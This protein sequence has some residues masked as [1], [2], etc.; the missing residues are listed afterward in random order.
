MEVLIRGGKFLVFEI[1]E[2]EKIMRV[3]VVTFVG[4]KGFVERGVEVGN[5]FE[6]VK[7]CMVV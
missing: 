5:R 1:I 4:G 2:K 7:I 3:G 6:F